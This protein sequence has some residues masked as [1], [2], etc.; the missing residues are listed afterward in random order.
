MGRVVV[1]EF[2]TMDGVV[3]D[4]DGSGGASFGGWAFKDGPETVAGDKFRLGAAMDEGVLLMGRK[5]WE[6]FARIWPG[7]ADD[8]AVRLN[9][10]P[11]L[12]ASSTLK[13][14]SGWSNSALAQVDP[15]D[16]VRNEDR[17]VIVTGS[18]SIVRALQEHDLVDEYRLLVFPSVVGEGAR[19]FPS[20]VAPI[21]LTCTSVEQAGA[22]VLTRYQRVAANAS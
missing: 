21:D 20:G 22:A 4:P 14:V 1:I 11:K 17:D 2:V 15:I 10:M 16:A 6:L 9:A 19:L 18:L 8:F 5:T 12:V 3:E 7:R 13:D